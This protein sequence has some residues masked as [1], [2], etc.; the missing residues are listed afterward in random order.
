MREEFSD[1]SC[2]LISVL[3]VLARMLEGAATSGPLAA[4]LEHPEFHMIK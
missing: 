2:A 4:W 1:S 3:G